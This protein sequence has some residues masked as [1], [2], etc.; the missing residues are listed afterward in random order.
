M[1][2]IISLVGAVVALL[3]GHYFRILRWDKFIKQYEKPP[4]SILCRALSL[5]YALNLILPIRGGDILRTVYVGRHMRNG[6]GFALAT[7]ILDRFLDII[8]VAGIFIMFQGA[9]M[10]GSA[11]KGSVVLYEILIVIIGM[12]LIICRLFS[13][14]VKKA[15]AGVC[16]IFNDKI[17]LEGMKFF[18]ALVNTFR[19]LRKIDII[20]VFVVTLAMWAA[21]LSSY[22]LFAFALTEMGGF[23]DVFITLFSGTSLG[24]TAL[25]SMRELGVN[26]ES[27]G[28]AW[29]LIYTIVPILVLYAVTLLPDMFRQPMGRVTAL[30]DSR[31]ED[32]HLSIL[33]QINARD[34]MRFLDDYFSSSNREFIKKF[35]ELNRNISILRDYSAG[36]NATTMLCMDREKTF[37]R[38]YAFGKDGEKLKEQLDWLEKH[39]GVIPL[40]D[41]VHKDCGNGYCCYDMAYTGNAYGMFQ[42]MHSQPSERSWDILRSALDSLRGRLYTMNRKKPDRASVERYLAEKVDKNLEKIK[43]SRLLS[44]FMRQEYIIINGKQYKNLP[45]MDKL[46]DHGY[47][48]EVFSHDKYSDIHGDLTIENIICLDNEREPSKAYYI[49]DPNTG[50]IHDSP[51]LD[52]GKLLQSLHGGYEFMMM[53]K[54]VK[55]DGNRVD[56]LYTRSSIYDEM[57]ERLKGYLKGNFMEQE[58]RSIFHHELIHWLRLMPYKLENDKKRAAMFYSGLVM[59]ANDIEEWYG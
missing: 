16:S 27:S 15:V 37:Y 19:D 29:I 56:F 50:N 48:W 31:D 5:G 47:L 14:Q 3:L 38:K 2:E 26:A 54:T 18:W 40:C 51:F 43:G 53:T 24:Q 34:Q 59:V 45:V 39:Q 35:I 1:I 30:T 36:S 42:Y 20:S 13:T 52:F 12:G 57:L 11:V 10:V 55:V 58:V 32:D 41:I 25:G 8:A 21:Y 44:D 22:G 6:M 46:F 49:I 23:T 4:V 33:P 9:G 28:V 17:R 7:V